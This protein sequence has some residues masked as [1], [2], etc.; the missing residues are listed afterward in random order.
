MSEEIQQMELASEGFTLEDQMA[1]NEYFHDFFDIP[2]VGFLAAPLPEGVTVE[3]QMAT[4][5]YL[6]D[7]IGVN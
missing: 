6:R 2:A 7:L 5:E 4:D 3:D 1:T